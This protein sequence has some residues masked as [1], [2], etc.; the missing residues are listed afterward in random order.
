M[1]QQQQITEFESQFSGDYPFTS[2]GVVVGTPPASFEEEMQTMIT[3]AGGTIDT[4]I[5]YHENMHQWWGDNV[6]EGGYQL[7]FYKE[8]M[9]TLAEFLFQARQA[10]R[11]AGG[12]YT[13]KGQAAFQASLVH[14]FKNDYAHT[15]SFWTVAPSNPQASGLFSGASTYDRP[16]IG[17]IALRQILG[18]GNFTRALEQIQRTYGGASVTEAQLVAVFR[19]WLPVQTAACQARLGTFFKQWWDTAYPRGGGN[20][21]PQI[22]GPGLVGINFYRPGGGC[23]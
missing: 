21:R 16:G 8:G 2:D 17:Y 3:F 5:L 14:T 23:S 11:K 13:H 20:N 9:A 19:Q 6:T 7:T 18:H 12:P 10:E 15:G 4:D 22:T 1:N